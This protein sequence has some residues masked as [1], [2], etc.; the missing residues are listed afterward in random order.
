MARGEDTRHDPRRQPGNWT[1]HTWA[2]DETES[3][4]YRGSHGGRAMAV[5]PRAPGVPEFTW[6]VGKE[7]DNTPYLDPAK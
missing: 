3:T 2:G 4:H 5:A 1:S 7:A 6:S